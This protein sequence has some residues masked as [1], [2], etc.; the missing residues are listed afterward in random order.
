MSVG[1]KKMPSPVRPAWGGQHPARSGGNRTR[2]TGSAG[3]AGEPA[4]PGLGRLAYEVGRLAARP[5]GRRG[6][7]RPPDTPGLPPAWAG[8]PVR[9]G[10]GGAEAAGLVPAWDTIT[11]ERETL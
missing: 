1:T 3:D 6:A 5:G 4:C 11:S 7:G 9:V 8:Q 2:T 10:R